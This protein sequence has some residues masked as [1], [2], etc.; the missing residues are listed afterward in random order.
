METT[1]LCCGITYDINDYQRNSK[2][3]HIVK[4]KQV[5][6]S[7]AYWYGLAEHQPENMF[8]INHECF[9]FEKGKK[10]P[11]IYVLRGLEVFR[12]L[13][14][15]NIGRVP[16]YFHDILPDNARYIDMET[17]RII[18]RAHGQEC[19]S[20]GCWDR[21]HCFWYPLPEPYEPW[22]VVPPKHRVGGEYCPIFINKFNLKF[23]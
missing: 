21:Y 19:Q 5:C 20:K 10:H 14:V 15:R 16:D 4:N 22:N 13:N 8:I 12:S 17:Y 6:I 18:K 7:C 11:G 23:L 9:M 3:L 1:C 2:L